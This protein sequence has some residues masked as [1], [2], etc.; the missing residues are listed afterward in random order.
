M[1]R[2]AG[3]ACAQSD[4]TVNGAALNS[5]GGVKKSAEP[6]RR[7]DEEVSFSGRTVLEVRPARDPEGAFV[8][9][10]LVETRRRARAHVSAI[11]PAVRRT[12]P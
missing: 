11:P 4:F 5:S 2:T 1:R 3:R 8:R 12:V 9:R 7:G 6:G 10:V